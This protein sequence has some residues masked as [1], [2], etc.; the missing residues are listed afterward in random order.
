MPIIKHEKRQKDGETFTPTISLI[1]PLFN[2]EE[3]VASCIE[4][5]F[6]YASKYGGFV[7]IFLVDN[8]SQDQTYEMAYAA[9]EINKKKFPRLRTKLIRLTERLEI[10]EIIELCSRYALGQKMALVKCKKKRMK[11]EVL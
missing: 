6:N 7:E 1:V 2:K 3:E 5:I 11:A 9:I 4:K 8:G 10:S